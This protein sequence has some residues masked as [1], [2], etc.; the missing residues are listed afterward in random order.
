ME[1]QLFHIFRNTPLGRE[2]LF[3]STYFCSKTGAAIN[4][5]VPEFTKFL[6]YFENDVIQINLDESYLTAPGSALEHATEVV[7]QKNIKPK[8]IKPKHFTASTLPDIP[9]GFDFMCCPRSISDL[10]SK[11][12]IGYIGP[13][14]R[15]IVKSARFPVLITSP[16][17]KEWSSI[18]VFFGGS[19]NA[20]NALKLGFRIKRATKMPLYIFTQAEKG[21]K[22]TCKDVIKHENLEKEMEQLADRWQIFEKGKFEENLYKVPHDSL[23]VLGAYGHGFIKDIV[24]GSKMEKIQSTVSNNLLI[25]GPN[26]TATV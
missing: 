4:I 16:V 8:F 19:A 9:T 3:Q 22:K 13:R 25:V 14:V 26:Y 1:A 18:T 12:G 15:R 21:H 23:V 6:M 5:Y 17:Y 10:S 24:F 20:V 11:I 2:T 7:M